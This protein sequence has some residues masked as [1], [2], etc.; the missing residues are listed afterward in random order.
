MSCVRVWLAAFALLL[1]PL[2]I[3][4][5][6]AEDQVD[7][8]L[9]LAVDVSYSMDLDEL[10]LQRDGYVKAVTSPEFLN[11]L[12]LG[13]NGRVAI[14]YVEWAGMDEQKLVVDWTFIGG[15]GDAQRF[16]AAIRNAP[17][18]RV[19]RTSIS[20]AMEYS[21]GLIEHNA[22]KGL[23]RV[24]DISGD[25][26][27]NQ[28]PLVDATRDSVVGRGITI[29]GL[30][31][32]LKEPAGSM[33]DIGQ[34]DIY[35]E[36]CVIGGPGAFVIPVRG[37]HEFADAIKTKLVMEIAGVK[38]PKSQLMHKAAGEQRVSCSVGER[39]WMERWGN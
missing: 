22:I 39:M 12:K 13:P 17:L 29:N 16:A 5:A 28:G 37:T 25:G 14:A 38:P 11:A 31:L 9:V 8:E 21:A 19:Y 30:P 4:D 34:L 33:L 32:M 7:V 24:I 6:R 2:A 1:G 10:A 18:R 27:N 15:P 23:R 20:G 35:Y 36:D 26:T 3:P